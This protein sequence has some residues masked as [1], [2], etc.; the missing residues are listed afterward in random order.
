MVDTDTLDAELPAISPREGL[1]SHASDGVHRPV[2]A[3]AEVFGIAELLEQIILEVPL[4]EILGLQNVSKG[5]LAAVR[6]S[7]PVRRALGYEQHGQSKFGRFQMTFNISWRIDG[8]YC[9][10]M[11][12]GAAYGH[13]PFNQV[14]EDRGTFAFLH[15]DADTYTHFTPTPRDVGSWYDMHLSYRRLKRCK[16]SIWAGTSG[17][18]QMCYAGE[19]ANPTLGRLYEDV[20]RRIMARE[21]RRHEGRLKSASETRALE[22]RFARDSLLE[23]D[24]YP[25]MS[26]G[27]GL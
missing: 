12:G 13:E 25:Y 26:Q 22:M 18:F 5:F 16:V 4:N 7:L 17:Q 14:I 23:Q 9:I 20:V 1:E 2:S 8:L 27:L 10:S 24:C 15:A 6:G 21:T 19:D 3:A 11:L